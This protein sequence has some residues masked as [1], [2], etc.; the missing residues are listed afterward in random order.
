R[1]GRSTGR[2]PR[3]CSRGV[4]SQG[5]TPNSQLTPN[6]QLPIGSFGSWKSG[7]HW[8]LGVGIWGLTRSLCRNQ[9]VTSPVLLPA[10]F[11]LFLAERRFFPL[12]D[13]LQPVGGNAEVGQVRAHGGRATLAEGEV[14]LRRT[15]RVAV[16]LDHHLRRGPALHPLGVFLQ[17][18]LLLFRH[19]LLVQREE[20]VAERLLVVQV[21]Q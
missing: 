8:E 5:P 4:N 20:R 7:V 21:R 6:A 11:V 15:A 14:V 18:R 12:A 13:D 3:D 16:A 1:R 9:K 10:G 17:R 2:G 19:F